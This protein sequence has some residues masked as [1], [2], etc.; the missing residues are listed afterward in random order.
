MR[1]LR[2]QRD[3]SCQRRIARSSAARLSLEPARCRAGSTLRYAEGESLCAR[4]SSRPGRM[5]V[6]EGRGGVLL[7]G[8]VEQLRSIADTGVCV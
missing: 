5:G 8:R 6:R 3:A 7:A 4:S 2:K 1:G